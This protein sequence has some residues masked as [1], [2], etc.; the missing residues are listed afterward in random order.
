MLK[1]IEQ[2][3]MFR[4]RSNRTLSVLHRQISIM[5]KETFIIFLNPQAIV[6]IE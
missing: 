3:F 6:E 4:H 1:F 2:K 5:T